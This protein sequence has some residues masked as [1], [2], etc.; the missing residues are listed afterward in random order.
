MSFNPDKIEPDDAIIFSR[1]TKNII[2]PNLYFNNVPIVKA[3]S[4]KHLG[5]N[6]EAKLM[7]NDHINEKICKSKNGIGLPGSRNIFYH[8]QVC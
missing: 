5:I 7:F 6:L 3:T 8:A 2:Y 4:Q 1:K